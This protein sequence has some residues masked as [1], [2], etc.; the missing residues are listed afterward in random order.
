VLATR[1]QL[2]SA[3]GRF[4]N[5]TLL[6]VGVA[7]TALGIARRAVDEMVVLAGSKTPAGASRSLA[8]HPPAQLHVAQAEAILGSARAF[9]R[10][11]VS[12]A[13]QVA[14]AGERVAVDRRARVR[15]ACAHAGMEA[16]RATDLAYNTGGGSSVFASSPLQR[17]F[18][19]VH[20]ATQHIMLSDRNH[21]TFGRLRLG[22]EADTSLL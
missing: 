11:E 10:H 17:C 3:L 13:W 6:A 12:E 22:L 19:D 20:T 4:P 16:A 1:S 7:A 14:L 8:H 15:L 5:F 2:D 9:L 21:L 18:R